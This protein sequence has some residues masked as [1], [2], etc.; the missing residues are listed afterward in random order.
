MQGRLFTLQFTAADP[1]GFIDFWQRQYRDQLETLYEANI[2]VKPFTDKAIRELFEW[3]N[4]GALS[5][6][7]GDSVER[8]YIARKQEPSVDKAIGLSGNA[9]SGEI[10]KFAKQFLT[11]DFRDGGA[12]W[13]IFW[14]HCCNQLFPVYDQHVHRAMIFVEENR[15]EDLAQFPDYRKVELYLE[16]YLDFHSRFPGEQRAVDRAI[17]TFGRFMKGW[18]T[19]STIGK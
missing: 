8:N 2:S 16:K 9:S 14:L 11:I 5:A 7:K 10:A 4:G 18:P 17:H 12:I 19:V 3:K 6:P 13:R 15:V 1:A